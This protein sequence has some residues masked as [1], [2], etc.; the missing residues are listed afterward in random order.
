[1]SLLPTFAATELMQV[2]DDAAVLGDDD[3]HAGFWRDFSTALNT[4]RIG[5]LK[6]TANASHTLGYCSR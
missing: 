3:R 6:Q 1:M 2:S 5:F 4:E